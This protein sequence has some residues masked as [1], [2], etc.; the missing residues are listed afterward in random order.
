MQS[1]AYWAV[2]LKISVHKIISMIR[3][4]LNTVMII[5]EGGGVYIP[6]NPTDSGGRLPIA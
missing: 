6:A 2:F 3:K 5:S 4:P 1:K